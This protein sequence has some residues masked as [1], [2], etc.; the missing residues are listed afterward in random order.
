LD[1]GTILYILSVPLLSVLGTI[2]SI[3][4]VSAIISERRKSPRSQLTKGLRRV[5]FVSEFK[6]RSCGRSIEIYE[7]R[8]RV[9][10]CQECGHPDP[11]HISTRELREELR[12][13]FRKQLEPTEAK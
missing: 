3:A 11:E 4:I 1:L 13:K 5:I 9:P 12:F 6:C 2:L 8:D 7:N 10:F